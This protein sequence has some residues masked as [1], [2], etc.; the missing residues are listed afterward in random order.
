MLG[1]NINLAAPEVLI[2]PNQILR[3][4]AGGSSL[5][6]EGNL[7]NQGTFSSRNDEGKSSM[8]LVV[9]GT[10]TNSNGAVF[11]HG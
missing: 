11:N 4:R 9:T 8:Q 7:V 2:E 5:A 10:V 3:T 1:N 6:I